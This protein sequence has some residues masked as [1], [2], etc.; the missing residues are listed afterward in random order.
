MTDSE[1]LDLLLSKMHSVEGNVREAKADIAV[2]KED[3]SDLKE[4]MAEVKTDISVMKA[5]ISGLKEEMAEVKTDISVMKED[6]SVLKEEMT[7]VKTDI[8]V[9]KEEMTEVK[10][11]IS[12]LKADTS[13]MKK[14]MHSMD[15]RLRNVELILENETNKNIRFLAQCHQE[16]LEKLNQSLKIREKDEMLQIR[17]NT[18]EREV[19]TLNDYVF[20]KAV[21]A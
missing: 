16:L 13:G 4:E 21:M 3:I 17:V 11:D 7:E 2:M 15:R 18:L 1:K 8:S 10:S 14:Q 12:E 5:D 19:K 9:L 6:I 20:S